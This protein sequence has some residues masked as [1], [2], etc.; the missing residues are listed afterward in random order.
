MSF[1]YLPLAL[2]FVMFGTLLSSCGG[3]TNTSPA[4]SHPAD[5]SATIHH[6]DAL[7]NK[8]AAYVN[9][10][11]LDI[12]VGVMQLERGDT[13]SVNGHVHYALMS[14]CKFPQ[15]ITLLHLVDDGKLARNAM[16]HITPY[17]L[18]Q[19][20]HSSL[21]KDHPKAPFDLTIPEALA[22]SIG[23]SDNITSNVIF[24]LDGG[25][26]AVES[27]IHSLGIVEIGVGTDYRHMRNDSLYRNWIT[28]VA[29]A[30]L[31]NKFY[32]QKIL[33]DTSR[34]TLWKAMVEAPNGKDRLPGML[35]GG[36]VIGHKTGTAGRDS[37]NACTAFNDIGIMQLP[38]G[39]H[40]AVAVFIAKSAQTDDENAKTIAEIGKLVWD[41]YAAK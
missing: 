15:A 10:K 19:P 3:N 32:T 40:V 37:A 41:Y 2:A 5:T 8:I 30:S 24:A 17:D 36:T 18:T 20:T 28:P 13:L 6:Q 27:Y 21:H 1:K 11:H 25:P 35:P 38:D 31:L 34:A 16:V 9:A 39:K 12:G 23:Q 26:A 33:T 14:V 29:A 22:Y 4:N 7:R